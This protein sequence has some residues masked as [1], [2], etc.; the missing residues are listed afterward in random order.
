MSVVRLVD[1]REVPLDPAE[2][3]D[4][5]RDAEGGGL[6]LFVGLVRDHDHGR[7]VSRLEYSAHPTAAATIREVAEEVA[8]EFDVL[9]V[10]AVH[11]TGMLEIGDVAVVT[12][13]VAAHRGQAFDANR[14]LIDRLKQRTPIWKHQLFADGDEEWVGTP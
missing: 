5:V 10:A 3:L 13:A 8:A 1:V 4:A 11:R 7:G 6:D 12:A 14:A 2:V 9:A